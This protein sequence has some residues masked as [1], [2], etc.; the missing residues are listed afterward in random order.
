MFLVWVAD[1]AR[2]ERL[3][4]DKSVALEGLPYTDS[5]LTSTI[6]CAVAAQNAVVAAESLGLGV[7]YVGGLRNDAAA[8]A[9][10]VG[11]PPHAYG[12]FGMA[13]G[14]ADPAVPSAVKPR[15]LQA[16]VLHRETYSVDVQRD[17]IARHDRAMP[18]FRAEQG[19]DD[20][21]WTDLTIS[22]MARIAALNG[23][24]LLR[25]VLNGLGFGL[26]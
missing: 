8:V 10:I 21:S 26:K 5:F 9:G 24:H 23:R 1:L 6:D 7:L 11:L 13:L 20:I 18:D 19:M 4:N 16:A 2:R 14:Y 17:A 15:L 25:D 12:V 22:R 3:A